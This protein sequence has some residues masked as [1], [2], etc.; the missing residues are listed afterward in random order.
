MFTEITGTATMGIA[1]SEF[2]CTKCN[3][4]TYYFGDVPLEGFSIG[5]EPY[6]T[7]GTEI[8]SKCGQRFV[9]KCNHT[10]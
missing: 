4:P 9:P 3:K 7:C 2:F 8:C 10:N 1:T 5:S 6:C